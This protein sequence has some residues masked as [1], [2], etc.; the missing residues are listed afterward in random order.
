MTENPLRFRL[1]GVAVAAASVALVTG[2]IFALRGAVPVLSTGVLYLLAVLL[3]SSYWGLWL[4][5]A[6][7]VASAAAFNFFHIPPA[8]RLSVAE[9]ENWVALG[10]YF[11]VAVVVSTFAGAA[12]ARASEAERGRREADL[13]A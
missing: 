7:S 10:V 2:V 3:V 8:G 12:R 6:T 11:M 1:A 5:V 4:G 13:S 9:P